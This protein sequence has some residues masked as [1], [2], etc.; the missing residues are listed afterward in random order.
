M[1]KVMFKV[2]K[3]ICDDC[4]LALKRFIGHMDGVES[5]DVDEEGK[6]AIIFDKSRMSRE[7]L[8]SITKGS[9]EKLG[10]RLLD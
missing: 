8:F 2:E 10:Y 6:I 3:S 5:V 7:M 4:V 1:E 9:I